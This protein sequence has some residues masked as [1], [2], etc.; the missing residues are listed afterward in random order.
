[1]KKIETMNISYKSGKNVG[2]VLA[3]VDKVWQRYSQR[4][5][6]DE[7]T[8]FFK[9]ALYKKPLYHKTNLLIVRAVKQ[10]ATA[11]ITLLLIVNVPEWFGPS[12]LGYF[13]NLLRKSAD[14]K[15]VP[16]KFLVRKKG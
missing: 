15:G 14:L 5:S 11:P 7:L 2:K 3:K 8:F 6:D 12:Q 1:M 4:F 10:I 13:D 9:E 16:I